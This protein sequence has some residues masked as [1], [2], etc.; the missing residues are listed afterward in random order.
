MAEDTIV[1]DLTNYKDRVGATVAP[2]RYRVQVEDVEI[3]TSSTG[4]PMITTWLR[5][6][7]GKFD[8]H[9]IIDRL[10]QTEGAKWRTVSF[11]QAL[12]LPTPNKRLN[13]RTSTWVGRVLDIDV[14]DGD[15]YMGRIKS[16]VRGHMRVERAGGAETVEDELAAL[17]EFAPGAKVPA[18]TTM[19]ADDDVVD[20][21]D[22]GEL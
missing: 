4:N 9:T 1:I 15:P 19:S 10:A 2:G 8:G 16:E 17:G 21:D 14:E 3:G 13:V 5:I 6:Q 18:D 7:G 20:L 22:L 11:M 12:G